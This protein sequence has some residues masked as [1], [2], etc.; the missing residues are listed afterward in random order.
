M[1]VLGIIIICLLASHT[2]SG[3]NGV[4]YEEI[5]ATDGNIIIE[6]SMQ[7][8]PIIHKSFHQCSITAYC[9]YVI[10]NLTTGHFSMYNSASDLPLNRTGLHIW[11][12]L[13]HGKPEANTRASFI[14]LSSIFKQISKL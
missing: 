2:I 14:F 4:Y 6:A 11:K 10:K 9:N 3:A 8:T 13:Y 5:S 12:K 7:R 1:R